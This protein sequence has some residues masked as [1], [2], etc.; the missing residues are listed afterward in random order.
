MTSDH[1]MHVI[2]MMRDQIVPHEDA[3]IVRSRKWVAFD[4]STDHI[5]KIAKYIGR[6]SL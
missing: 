2:R 5:T 3:V 4:V 1:L 6:C